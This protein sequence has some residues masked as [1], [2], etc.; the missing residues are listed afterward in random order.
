M[1][2]CKFKFFTVDIIFV[3]H[4]RQGTRLEFLPI[5]CQNVLN[6]YLSNEKVKLNLDKPYC[7]FLN[8]ME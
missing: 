7:S 6:G 1:K 5:F 3:L 4:C 8:S 2:G